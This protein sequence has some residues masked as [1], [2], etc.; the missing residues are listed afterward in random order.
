MEFI[1]HRDI[2]DKLLTRIQ[3]FNK[4]QGDASSSIISYY[5]VDLSGKLQ[6][7]CKP[8]DINAVTWGVFPGEEILQPTIVEQTSF[9]AWKDEVYRL[10]SEWNKVLSSNLVDIDDESKLSNFT[11]LMNEVG[12][13][14]VL[15]NLV[16]NDFIDSNSTLFSLIYD[17]N[18]PELP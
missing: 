10:F 14:F 18:L 12:H 7:N 4:L 5:A 9:L 6:T 2:V 11:R 13:E 1:C 17:L 3:D 15:C 16:N 8:D